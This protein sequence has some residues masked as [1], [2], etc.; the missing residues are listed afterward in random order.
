MFVAAALCLGL[1]VGS[2]LNVVVHRVP[3]GESIVQPGSHCPRCATPIKAW[4]NVPLLSYLWLRGRCRDCQAP[5]SA[6]YPAIELVTG[7]TFARTS[8][9][10]SDPTVVF[11]FCASC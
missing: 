3:R 10:M 7:L 4:N 11:R 2:F 8:D 5:I 6:R 1:V 9:F